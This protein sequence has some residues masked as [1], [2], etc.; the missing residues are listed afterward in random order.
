MTK[1]ILQKEKGKIV[2]KAINSGERDYARAI[3]ASV[4]GLW[5]GEFDLTSFTDAMVGAIRRGLVRAWREGAEECGIAPEELTVEELR[6]MRRFVNAQYAYIDGFGQD[7]DENSKA[8]KGKLGPHYKRAALWVNRY[9]EARQ[10]A[11]QLAP[12]SQHFPQ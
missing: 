9:G 4:Y 7:I 3:R 2:A 12:E 11:K 5:T 6:Q 1:L 8:N 10:F